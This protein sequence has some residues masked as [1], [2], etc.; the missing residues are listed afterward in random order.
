MAMAEFQ[1]I[2]P[3]EIQEN[4]FELIGND[5][6][7]LTAARK[8]Q[9]VNTMTI[10]WGMMG[11]MWGEPAVLVT[12]RPQRFTKEFMDESDTF[13]LSF[14]ERH[15]YRK[16][17]GFLGEVSGRDDREKIQKSGLTIKHIDQTPYVDEAKLVMILRKL[18]VQQIDPKLFIDHE[19][20][21]KWYSNK[22]FHFLYTA[23]V[24]K[25]LQK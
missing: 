17:L 1:I 20:E 6:A 15:S 7:L 16:E 18:Y 11:L 25:V 21:P 4:P 2:K 3:S 5:W 10:S 12:V 19:I 13:S 14:F 8:N 23:R 22:N 9:E 24:E